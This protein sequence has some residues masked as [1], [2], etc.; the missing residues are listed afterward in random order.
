MLNG[1]FTYVIY[2]LVC[3]LMIFSS[4]CISDAVCVFLKHL[5]YPQ[6]KKTKYYLGW[7]VFTVIFQ[8]WLLSYM[9]HRF[10]SIK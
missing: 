5:G 4:L 1:Y 10:I 2:S 8:I 9:F 3:V 6:T 7:V